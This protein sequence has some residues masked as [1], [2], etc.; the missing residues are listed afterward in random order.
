MPPKPRRAAIKAITRKVMAQP[1]IGL[2]LMFMRVGNTCVNNAASLRLF[3]GRGTR[4]LCVCST[5]YSGICR[6][7]HG[8]PPELERLSEAVARVVLDRDVHRD[9]DQP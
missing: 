3:R 6:S 1:I 2:I 5:M 9:L 7:V 4:N 8:P